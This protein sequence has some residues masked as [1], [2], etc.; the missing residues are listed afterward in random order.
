[1]IMKNIPEGGYN[2]LP[3]FVKYNLLSQKNNFAKYRQFILIFSLNRTPI[4][5]AIFSPHYKK[6]NNVFVQ[7]Y[8]MYNYTDEK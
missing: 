5:S 3:D 8:I 4:L 1:M 7:Q 6:Q 2:M